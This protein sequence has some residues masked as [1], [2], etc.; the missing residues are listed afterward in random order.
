MKMP[1]QVLFDVSREPR[2]DAHGEEID[3]DD[4][5]ELRDGI[6][7]QIAG[8]RAGDQLVDQPAGRDREDGR[9]EEEPDAAI[10]HGTKNG[11][12]DASPDCATRTQ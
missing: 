3:A 8:E 11:T 7:E 12:G 6:A 9:E 5:G 2:A 4:G 10:M 1:Q